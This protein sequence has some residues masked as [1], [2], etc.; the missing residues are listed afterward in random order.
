MN[1]EHIK[2]V[3]CYKMS[4]SFFLMLK[5]V[6]AISAQWGKIILKHLQWQIFSYSYEPVWLFSAICEKKQLLAV[7]WYY[8]QSNK[9]FIQSNT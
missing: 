3:V 8:A 6:S 5:F 9:L 1:E 2:L 7:V 4:F